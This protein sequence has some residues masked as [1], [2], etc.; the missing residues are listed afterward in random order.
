[1]IGAHER[2]WQ[3]L[4]AHGVGERRNETS[5]NNRGPTAAKNPTRRGQCGDGARSAVR[6]QYAALYAHRHDPNFDS[7]L[8]M[9]PRKPLQ[10]PPPAASLLM[11][12]PGDGISP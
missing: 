3:R 5:R 7:E 1:L 8:K 2:F 12:V 9:P 4:R 10:F 11:S 6:T